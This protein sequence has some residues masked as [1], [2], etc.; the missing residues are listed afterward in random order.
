MSEVKMLVRI[1][2]SLM[3]F[4]GVVS[5]QVLSRRQQLQLQRQQKQVDQQQE[6]LEKQLLS[7]V[8]LPQSCNELS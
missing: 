7:Q 8:T 1:V 2:V 6:M 3:L 5:G 4:Y